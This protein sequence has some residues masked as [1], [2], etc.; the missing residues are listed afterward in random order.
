MT[1]FDSTVDKRTEQI[2]DSWVVDTVL[3][4]SAREFEHWFGVSA[5]VAVLTSV[6]VVLSGSVVL[7][8][9]GV[10]VTAGALLMDV[11][12]RRISYD[13]HRPHKLFWSTMSTVIV[14]TGGVVAL[15]VIPAYALELE[16]Y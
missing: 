2:G 1:Q 16:S 14:L 11:S 3:P 13:S 9:S 4:Q 15:L 7:W 10:V 6:S 8:L 12:H 5:L